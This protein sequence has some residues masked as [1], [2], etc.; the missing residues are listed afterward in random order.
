MSK[1]LG[2]AEVDELATDLLARLLHP[3]VAPCQACTKAA[4]AKAASASAAECVAAA[5]E[6]K[7]EVLKGVKVDC[8]HVRIAAKQVCAIFSA[9]LNYFMLIVLSHR[10]A[11]CCIS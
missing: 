5:E 6:D 9:V 7:L 3:K 11:V 10:A 4:A 8:P 1:D 2:N